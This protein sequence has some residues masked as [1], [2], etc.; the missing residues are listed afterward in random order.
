MAVD[1]DIQVWLDMQANTRQT[2]IVPYVQSARD[3]RVNFRMNVTQNSD[4]GTSR[5]S[6]EGEISASAATPTPLARVTLGRQ[7]GGECRVEVVLREGQ[8]NVGTY[9]FSCETQ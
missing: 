1:A 8:Q 7:Q 2:V 6:Q 4:S 5:S 9:H 3:I